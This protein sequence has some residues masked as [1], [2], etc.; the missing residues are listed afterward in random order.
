[1][2][3]RALVLGGGGIAGIAWEIGLLAGLVAEG[4]DW[5]RQ[6]REK[7]PDVRIGAD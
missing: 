4:V 6:W 5:V 2:S 3:T 1:M 7:N